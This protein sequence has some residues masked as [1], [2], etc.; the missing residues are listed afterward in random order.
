MAE[1]HS[2]EDDGL[3]CPEVGVWSKDKHHFLRR[4]I[5]ICTKGMKN[6]HTLH[7]VDLFASAGIERIKDVGTLEWG[8]ALI[9]AQASPRFTQLHLCELKSDRLSALQKR[10][11]Q[12]PQPKAPQCI[13]GD[14]NEAVHQII[15]TIP[16]KNT[17]TLAFLDPYGLNIY[18]E[19]VKALTADRKVD[20]MIYFPD[21]VD[22]ARNI[23]LHE[24]KDDS[25]LDRFLGMTTW[26]DATKEKNPVLQTEIIKNLYFGQMRKIGYEFADAERIG[27]TDGIPLYQ[28]LFFSKHETGMD[29]WRKIAS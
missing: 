15:S 23:E 27:R 20:L 25:R 4:Y 26:R 5:D 14:A 22:I 2:P 8:S 24:Q 28:I 11:E 19:T 6:W 18:Y 13:C 3:V 10:L 12:F 17:L 21:A 29:F 9:A 16:T 1:L 7:Y